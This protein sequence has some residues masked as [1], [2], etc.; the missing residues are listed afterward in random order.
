MP[1]QF[2]CQCFH[3][4]IKL[5][6]SSAHLQEY[7]TFL[8]HPELCAG[9][10]QTFMLHKL[11]DDPYFEPLPVKLAACRPC[12]LEDDDDEGPTR[13]DGPSLLNFSLSQSDVQLPSGT[14]HVL[15]P[16]T[17]S[18]VP[19]HSPDSTAATPTIATSESLLRCPAAEVVKVRPNWT[20]VFIDHNVMTTASHALKFHHRSSD[21]GSTSRVKPHSCVKKKT[22]GK[23]R[24]RGTEED[25]GGRQTKRKKGRGSKGTS[26]VLPLSGRVID[27]ASWGSGGTRNLERRVLEDITNKVLH[28][29]AVT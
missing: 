15:I 25:N 19:E 2:I 20:S 14:A 11:P 6:L 13:Q 24:A 1:E 28:A 3:D 5:K 12:I 8:S 10:G 9:S 4:E 27:K 22:K 23:K 7:R 18:S 16:S 21:L 29:Q 17:L 26:G